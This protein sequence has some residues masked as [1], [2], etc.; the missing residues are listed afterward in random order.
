MPQVCPAPRDGTLLPNENVCLYYLRGGVRRSHR[1]YTNLVLQVVYSRLLGRA[2]ES[3]LL[4]LLAPMTEQ[5]L[6]SA[7][8]LQCLLHSSLF[9]HIVSI[10]MDLLLRLR[11][12]YFITTAWRH[13]LLTA[14]CLQYYSISATSSRST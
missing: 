8:P 4:R 1:S 11:T 13:L 6:Y 7:Y 3:P 2:E 5:V 14:G 12:S 9:P 10:M